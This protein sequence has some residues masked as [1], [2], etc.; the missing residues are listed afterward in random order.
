MYYDC[1][2]NS[3]LELSLIHACCAEMNLTARFLNLIYYITSPQLSIFY[4]DLRRLLTE[5]LS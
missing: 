5:F 1:S 3:T 2:D 4:G